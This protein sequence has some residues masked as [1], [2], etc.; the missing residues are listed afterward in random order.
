MPTPDTDVTDFRAP[1][2]EP[3]AGPSRV[4]SAQGHPPEHNAI[5]RRSDPIHTCRGRAVNGELISISS[6]PALRSG[7]CQH[8]VPENSFVPAL[9]THIVP[10]LSPTCTLYFRLAR[11]SWLGIRKTSAAF[12]L[13][14][15]SKDTI[16]SSRR[17]AAVCNGGCITRYHVSDWCD[18]QV[19]AAT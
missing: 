7:A 16:A 10:Y 8:S 6:M 14:A 17:G 2:Q 18:T 3:L 12:W 15:P 4:L 9:C 19:A 11:A 13:S 1:P 5:P